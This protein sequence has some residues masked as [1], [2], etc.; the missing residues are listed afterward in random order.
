MLT[1]S[2]LQCLLLNSWAQTET[3]F[4]PHTMRFHL[5]HS[6]IIKLHLNVLYI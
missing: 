1:P 3:Q 4:V 6:I 2:L 5:G